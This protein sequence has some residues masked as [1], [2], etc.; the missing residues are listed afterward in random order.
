MQ[1]ILSSTLLLE[2]TKIKIFSTI[3]LAV[4]WYGCETWAITLREEHG[5]SGNRVLRKIFGTEREQVIGDW[6]KLHNL[7]L[8]DGIPH[9]LLFG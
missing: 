9:R 4:V 3:N 2:N 7:E 6:R 1:N 5:L 8:Y